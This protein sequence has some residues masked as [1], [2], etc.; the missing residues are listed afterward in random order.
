M[1]KN[2]IS[3]EQSKDTGIIIALILL[4]SGT[5]L[6][7]FLLIKISIVIIFISFLIPVLFYF[8]A[9]V[10]FGF[11]KIFGSV[12]SKIVLAIIFILAVFPVGL[13]RKAMKK[14]PMMIRSFKKGSGSAWTVR[15][16]KYSE[17]DIL[18]PY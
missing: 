2:K 12:V 6:K 15:E 13:I 18:K 5:V 16:H 7:S 11:S 8:P 1:E 17:S 3:K 14:D 4:L 10:W 9:I